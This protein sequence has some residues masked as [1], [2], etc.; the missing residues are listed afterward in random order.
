MDEKQL[1]KWVVIGVAVGVA[2]GAIAYLAWIEGRKV[3]PEKIKE[4]F[5][6]VIPESYKIPNSI[7]VVNITYEE[8]DGRLVPG[9]I[10]FPLGL[11]KKCP[12]VVWCDGWGGTLISHHGNLEELA[13]HSYVAM[14][15]KATKQDTHLEGGLKGFGGEWAEDMEDAITYLVEQSPVRSLIDKD[16][17]GVVGHSLGG[18]TAS[19]VAA[20]D[21]RVKAAV[22][23]SCTDLSKLAEVNV[24]IQIQTADFDFGGLLTSFENIPS[25]LLANPPKQLIVVQWGTHDFTAKPTSEFP[26]CYFD[27]RG[28]PPWQNKISLHYLL[29]WFD[30]FLKGEESAY[31]RIITPTEHLSRQWCSKYDLGKGEQ[32]MAGPFVKPEKLI[33]VTEIEEELGG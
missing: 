22:I 32:Q 25:Y 2:V 29:A 16:K 33:S 30:Y 10:Y 5:V 8:S 9:R 4:V 3:T 14:I 31:E 24:P 18:I 28:K 21:Q 23:L 15:F 26:K 13:R 6:E 12:A 20:E 7:G 27:E 11:T 19:R 17:L 1:K